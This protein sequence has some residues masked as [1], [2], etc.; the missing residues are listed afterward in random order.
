MAWYD[1]FK[2]FTYA[3]TQ[4]PLA[5]KTDTRGLD[6]AGISSPDVPDLRSADGMAMGANAFIRVQN[7]LV[8]MTTTT[9]RTNRYKE[10]ERLLASVAE[11]DMALTVLA[12]EACVAGS[13]EIATAFH[14]YQTIEW[15]TKHKK[16]DERFPVYCFD[17]E[18][19]DYTIGWA[20]HPR[21]VKNANTVNLILD[22]G[23]IETVTEDH[24]IL[25][26]DG[27]WVM[28]GDLTAGSEL[29]PFYRLDARTNLYHRQFPRLWTFNKGWIHERQFIDE[30]RLGRNL[31]E[32]ERLNRFART[33]ASGITI[34]LL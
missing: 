33:A 15:L 4:D 9:N 3:F 6:G 14:G 7:E 23:T 28:A 24:R 25:T 21:L 22:N 19:N 18:K 5:K 10:Y 27:G 26:R 17:F 32:Y 16:P 11:I 29:M 13:T 8:D 20:W 34:R 2:L 12:D 1:F 30:W 31:P